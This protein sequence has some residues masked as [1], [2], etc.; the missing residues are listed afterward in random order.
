MKKI[1]TGKTKDVYE[2]SSGNIQLVFKDDMTGKA[3][4][5]DPGSNEVGLTV[6][7]SGRAGLM[8][9]QYFFT[10]IEA[11][12]IAT[13][14]V[15]ADLDKQTMEVLPIEPF[16]KGLEVICRFEAAGSFVR[17]YGNYVKEGDPLPQLIE[18]SLKDD[19]RGDPF[20]EKETLV[21]LRLLTAQ[22]HDTL[23][24]KTRNISHIIQQLLADH[25]LHLIDI[26]LEFGRSKKTGDILLID[27]ISG[28]NMRVTHRGEPVH[29]LDIHRY[30]A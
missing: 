26:K 19:Q 3:G 29:P 8:L 9:S 24:E 7:G 22:E 25:Q 30:L 21:A 17:R 1:Y 15:N 10:A 13:H 6:P 14:F 23:I 12:G 2:L 16:G 28:G 20:I 18:I 11:A 4:V 27:E 5:F